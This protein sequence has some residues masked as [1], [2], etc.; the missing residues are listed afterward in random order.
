MGNLLTESVVMTASEKFDGK[1]F[2]VPDGNHDFSIAWGSER[3]PK[4]PCW[5]IEVK[6]FLPVSMLAADYRHA[7]AASPVAVQKKAWVKENGL[8]APNEKEV[9][10]NVVNHKPASL[11]LKA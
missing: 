11:A 10:L 7:V 2:E 4:Y 9:R 5:G 3:N 6:G 8:I 1:P